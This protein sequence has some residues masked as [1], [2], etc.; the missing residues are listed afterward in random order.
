MKRDDLT[1]EVAEDAKARK[2]QGQRQI[3]DIRSQRSDTAE[4]LSDLIF[5]PKGR[6]LSEKWGQKN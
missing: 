4:H 3:Q 2:D 1:T 5:L 6:R